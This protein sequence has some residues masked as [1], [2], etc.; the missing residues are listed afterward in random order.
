VSVANSRDTKMAAREAALQM[1]YALELGGQDAAQVE[2]WYL[3]AHPLPPE[4]RERAG[5]LV[6]TAARERERIESLIRRHARGWKLERISLIDRSLL[7][8]GVAELL[9]MPAPP[10]PAVIHACL[11]LGRKFS[12]PEVLNFLHGLLDAVARDLDS[13]VSAGE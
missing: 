4:V 7:K 1:L 12:Q 5:A 13:A 2:R 8:L 10:L 6:D 3:A 11:Q 9:L